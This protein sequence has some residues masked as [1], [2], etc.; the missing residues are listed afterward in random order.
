[1]PCNSDYL[2][3]NSR[4]Q[5][6]QHTAKLYVYL[7]HAIGIQPNTAAVAAAKDIYCRRDLVAPLCALLKSLTKAQMDEHV[8]NA[9]KKPA[10]ELA[11]WW[12]EHQAADALRKKEERK[13]ARK[14]SLAAQ[15]RAK[16]T[17]AE[18]KALKAELDD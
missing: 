8:Y 11:D 7:Q 12:E 4:E 14:R 2:A 10:R 13:A 5:Q 16:L 1:M 6:L 9:R 3:P 17:P 18:L 15:A